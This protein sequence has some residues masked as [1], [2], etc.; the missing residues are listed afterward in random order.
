MARVGGKEEKKPHLHV[1]ELSTAVLVLRPPGR[2]LSPPIVMVDPDLTPKIGGRL[3]LTIQSL[4]SSDFKHLGS[5]GQPEVWDNV[6]NDP[7]RLNGSAVIWLTP[8]S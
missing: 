1:L 6:R 8:T 2:S 7:N 3:D 5:Y 4:K